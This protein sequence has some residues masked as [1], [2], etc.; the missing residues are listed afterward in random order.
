MALTA[1]LGFALAVLT[2]V[3]PSS[4]ASPE[5]GTFGFDSMTFDGDATVQLRDGVI[6][7][8]P[9]EGAARTVVLGHAATVALPDGSSVRDA[10]LTLVGED[11]SSLRLSTGTGAVVRS[12][13][14][15]L[16]ASGKDLALHAE[17]TRLAT[18]GDVRLA[19]LSGSLRIDGDRSFV[20]RRVG[21][22]EPPAVA[23]SGASID[24]SFPEDWTSRVLSSA[25]AL[26]VVGSVRMFRVQGQ[27]GDESVGGTFERAGAMTL[28]A[29]LVEANENGPVDAAEPGP[30]PGLPLGIGLPTG[31]PRQ[32]AA[33]SSATYRPRVAASLADQ[34]RA[35]FE[36]ASDAP[37]PAAKVAF[38][39]VLAVAFVL[40]L[41]KSKAFA[42][43]ASLGS[44]IRGD[45]A[46]QHPAREKLLTLLRAHPGMRLAELE[47]ETG[48][49]R[50]TV[51]YHLV[52][53]KRCGLVEVQS[54]Y[55]STRYFLRGQGA[56][57]ETQLAQV[58]LRRARLSG[59]ILRA[60]EERPGVSVSEVSTRLDLHPSHT[61]YHLRKLLAAQLVDAR[62]E[63]RTR[64]LYPFGH[65]ASGRV[66]MP[67]GPGNAGA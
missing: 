55:G 50:N 36:V 8:G 54:R 22:A 30:A 28:S 57:G 62:K 43:L 56:L 18:N 65:L 7:I 66:F 44:R 52:L 20:L 11:A 51:E 5:S 61:M 14:G 16:S 42:L 64:R 29:R 60:V 19:L 17:P 38:A 24:A 37:L 27:W 15:S 45:E 4:A 41:K 3:S 49:M 25:L 47:R 23:V 9:S 13:G 12:A 6:R 67:H 53:L 10:T 2:L 31:Q 48:M 58:V 59:E 39:T 32:P 26:D 63:G 21:A 34:E 35:S 33:A 1:R 46:K 40:A